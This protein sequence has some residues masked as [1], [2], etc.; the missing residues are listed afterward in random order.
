M[1][2][3]ITTPSY[4]RAQSVELILRGAKKRRS[5]AYAN[6]LAVNSNAGVKAN[7]RAVE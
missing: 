4:N 3:K 7:L 1:L 5:L 2:K 6:A